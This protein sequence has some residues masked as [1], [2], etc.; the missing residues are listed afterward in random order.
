[1]ILTLFFDRGGNSCRSPTYFVSASRYVNR[2]LRTQ[3]RI[4]QSVRLANLLRV[5]GKIAVGKHPSTSL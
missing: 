5:C 2:E 4:P 3:A 1:L